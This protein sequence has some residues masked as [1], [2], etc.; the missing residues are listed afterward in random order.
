M[1]LNTK[2]AAKYNFPNLAVSGFIDTYGV[3]PAEVVRRIDGLI[4]P[5]R[6][7]LFGYVERSFQVGICGNLNFHRVADLVCYLAMSW[8]S[9][10]KT[11]TDN[12]FF[13]QYPI[14]VRYPKGSKNYNLSQFKGSCCPRNQYNIPHKWKG[15]QLSARLSL[16][17]HMKKALTE[18]YG[19]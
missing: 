19:L 13:E 3:D 6:N 12:A 4:S 17:R 9:P 14:L 5:F 16:L 10:Y 11:P 8:E 15:K 1:K 7:E 18:I 2:A